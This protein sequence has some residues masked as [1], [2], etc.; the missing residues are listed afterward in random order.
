MKV[1]TGGRTKGTPNKVPQLVRDRLAELDCDPI[2]QLCVI[3][4]QAQEEGNLQLA[5]AMFKELASF[6]A[7]KLRAI[8]ITDGNEPQEPLE[9]LEIVITRAK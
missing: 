6:V 7:P 1:K 8:E 2:Q 3:A 5:G 9:P 4:K